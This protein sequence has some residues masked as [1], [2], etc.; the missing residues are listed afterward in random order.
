MSMDFRV[1]L[2]IGLFLTSCAQV[3]TLSGG[4][5]DE[6]APN[7]I[8]ISPEN[9]STNFNQ[10]EISI[11]FDEYVALNNPQQNVYLVPADATPVISLKKKNLN[12]SWK[13]ELKPN[14]TYT[15]YLNGVVKDIH[16]G[17]DSLMTYVFST[18]DF[19]DTNSYTVF[20]KDA[21]ENKPVDKVLVGLYADSLA[22][23]PLYFSRT[24]A[25][26]KAQM[27][28]IKEGKYFLKAFADE[29]KN[30]AFNNTENIAFRAEGVKIKGQ[31][32]DSFPLRYFNP[33]S[34]KIKTFKLLPPGLLTVGSEDDL[35]ETQFY[36]NG[37]E[38]K[39]DE[40]RRITHDSLLIFLPNDTLQRVVLTYN[41]ELIQDT[42]KLNVSKK[43]HE[44][45]NSITCS[46]K[47][48]IV[49]PSQVLTFEVND[50]II[51]F[52]EQK[53]VLTNLKDSSII[54]H[55]KIIFDHN[56]IKI[57]IDKSNYS[58]V[59]VKFGRN[60][61]QTIHPGDM[62]E[63]KF[64]CTLK[65]P[66]EYGSIKLKVWEDHPVLLLKVFLKNEE[67][68]SIV[69]DITL[70]NLTINELEPGDYSFKVVEDLNENGIWDTG[71]VNLQLQPEIIRHFKGP[72]VRANWEIE[73]SL[74]PNE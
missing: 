30:L 72:T 23:K 33:L 41:N 51:A 59:E 70:N 37:K 55:K 4:D 29:D 6:F 68:N 13:E 69:I 44:T 5:T 28:N 63:I 74:N 15:L 53:I 47:N 65:K 57:E 20:V 9:Q 34:H 35:R 11:E 3:G 48:N 19:I 21:K 46:L 43:Q 17:N 58:Q 12:I 26:G 18:G 67:V 32:T 14:T 56:L 16:E 10:K 45:K 36:L 25:R 7:P 1:I 60:A 42:L 27:Q 71:D 2:I 8:K 39:E 61:I 38:L 73:T 31:V 52:D 40:I 22:N 54:E 64:N 50:K 66:R 49:A 24:D 62:S